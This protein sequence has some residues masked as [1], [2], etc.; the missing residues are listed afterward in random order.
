VSASNLPEARAAF[1]RSQPALVVLDRLLEGQDC[2]SFIREL[3]TSGYSGKFLVVSVVDEPDA[4]LGAGADAFL[5]KPISPTNLL[6][7]VRDLIEQVP[8]KTVLLVDDEEI[9]R[10]LLSE[11]LT[12]AGIR[13]EEAHNGREAIRM[14]RRRIPDAM[15]LDVGLPDLSGYE[16]LREIRV[17]TRMAKTPV[18]IHTSRLLSEAEEDKLVELG[19]GFF[20]KKDFSEQNGPEELLRALAAIGLTA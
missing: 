18:L 7:Q 19:A 16:V 1:K 6:N 14:A 11:A 8:A 17:D 2:L 12:K 5:A 13:V 3:K 9:A 4:A 10:Y 15:I 20:S